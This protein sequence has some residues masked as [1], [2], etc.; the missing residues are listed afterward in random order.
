MKVVLEL[1]HKPVR[2]PVV[3]SP[4]GLVHHSLAAVV[5]VHTAGQVAVRTAEQ[6][7]EDH[8]DMLG[9]VVAGLAT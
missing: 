6:V 4:L 1:R 3:D 2:A 9:I 5:A 8:L 7:A